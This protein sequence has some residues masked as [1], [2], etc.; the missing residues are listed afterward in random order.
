M[1]LKAN[2]CVQLAAEQMT[3]QQS[4]EPEM[5]VC[6]ICFD[7]CDSTECSPCACTELFAHRQCLSKAIAHRAEASCTVCKTPFNGLELKTRT[8]YRLSGLG[9]HVV[10]VSSIGA[11]LGLSIIIYLLKIGGDTTTVTILISLYFMCIL[12]I[13]ATLITSC[14]R[15]QTILERV[16]LPTSITWTVIDQTNNGGARAGLE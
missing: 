15:R 7:E 5:P 6:Y 9:V 16:V 1:Y 10:V 12:W 8:V 13:L 4:L 11:S 3:D 14:I 2:W